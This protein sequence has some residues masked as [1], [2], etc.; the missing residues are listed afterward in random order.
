MI[1]AINRLWQMGQGCGSIPQARMSEGVAVDL[2]YVSEIQSLTFEQKEMPMKKKRTTNLKTDTKN[3]KLT[4][5][6][7]FLGLI[8]AMFLMLELAGAPFA[9][10]Y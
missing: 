8:T 10:I 2:K 7:S 9:T 4:V 1:Q 5:K 3:I 6:L